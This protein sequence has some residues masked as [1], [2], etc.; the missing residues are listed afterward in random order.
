MFVVKIDTPNNALAKHPMPTSLPHTLAKMFDTLDEVGDC[1]TMTDDGAVQPFDTKHLKDLFDVPCKDVT[2]KIF[3]LVQSYKDTPCVVYAVKNVGALVL[4][5]LSNKKLLTVQC[6]HVAFG[7]RVSNA[8]PYCRNATLPPKDPPSLQN[9]HVFTWNE[10]LGDL[11]SRCIPGS[12]M[13]VTLTHTCLIVGDSESSC[14][15]HMTPLPRLYFALGRW[16][17]EWTLPPTLHKF[18]VIMH[19]MI[20]PLLLVAVTMIYKEWGERRND[21]KKRFK[22]DE[23]TERGLSFFDRIWRFDVDFYE[24]YKQV[25]KDVESENKLVWSCH[26]RA[27]KVVDFDES[28]PKHMIVRAHR[29]LDAHGRTFFHL[30]GQGGLD[31]DDLMQILHDVSIY[32]RTN[33]EPTRKVMRQFCLCG[34]DLPAMMHGVAISL[35]MTVCGGCS[36]VMAVGDHKRCKTCPAHLCPR[37]TKAVCKD[38]E[39]AK[40]S[41]AHERMIAEVESLRSKKSHVQQRQK[42]LDSEK[43]K[44]ESLAAERD[45]LVHEGAVRQKCMA[46]ELERCEVQCHVKVD[47]LTC[48]LE[49]TK[50]VNCELNEMLIREVMDN[51]RKKEALKRRDDEVQRYSKNVQLCN[52]EVQRCNQKVQLCND[53]VQRCNEELQRRLERRLNYPTLEEQVCDKIRQSLF[54]PSALR[55][56]VQAQGG[57]SLDLAAMPGSPFWT[58][59]MMSEVQNRYSPTEAERDAL[60]AKVRAAVEADPL[61]R[62]HDDLVTLG[63]RQ[64]TP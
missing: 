48:E 1:R 38:C 51:E 26:D 50:L 31:G 17:Q 4:F 33:P 45:R 32:R 6:S 39:D 57:Y 23:V 12:S 44:S 56:T 18:V 53:E 60:K 5:K 13:Y 49:E 24:A 10:P 34:G 37:C 62:L 27:D 19:E 8:S 30:I 29:R 47:S 25:Q 46:T 42:Q 3:K 21:Q 35:P 14:A 9:H 11:F 52:D 2:N 58:M 55:P 63:R 61:L 59:L 15:M 41:G 16:R 7:M 43:A 22:F 28:N 40:R 36:R 64:L 54:Q 20:F